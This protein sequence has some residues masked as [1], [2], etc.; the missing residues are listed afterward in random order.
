VPP[1]TFRW[2]RPFLAQ[3]IRD[4]TARRLRRLVQYDGAK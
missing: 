3:L 4:L 2:K 1:P